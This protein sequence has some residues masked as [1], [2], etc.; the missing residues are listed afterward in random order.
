MNIVPRVILCLLSFPAIAAAA[1]TGEAAKLIER[2]QMQKIPEEGAWFALTYRSDD[3][4]P[5]NSIERYK[6]VPHVAGSAI[7]GL[8][9]RDDFSAMHV[10][11]TDEIWHYYAGSPLELL[12]L[13]P[14]GRGEVVVLGPDV[15]MGQRPQVV[16]PRGVWQGAQ[17]LGDGDA[18]TLFGCTLAPGFEYGDFAIGYRDELQKSYPAFKAQIASLT[19]A[20]FASKPADGSRE[21]FPAVV[22]HDVFLPSDVPT[23][24]VAK[25]IA[26][27]ELAGRK[28]RIRS[29]AY[30]IAHFTLAP[31]T[32]MPASRNKTA[33][34][35]FL[36]ASGSGEVTLDGQSRRIRPGSVV[37]MKAGVVHSIRAMGELPLVFYAISAPAFSPEDYV[38]EP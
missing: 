36:V 23:I 32:A 31:G 28:A 6:A 5:A 19:R 34:E 4:L 18:Y 21:S 35:V 2:L 11:Q 10:L 17:P 22:R 8:V 27:S 33:E 38:L 24:D 3:V 20:E 16:V 30:S 9:T 25:G 1:P 15:L 37:L 13:H 29:D 12:L 14:D 26:L 7:H